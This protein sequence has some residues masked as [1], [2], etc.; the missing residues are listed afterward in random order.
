MTLEELREYEE[1]V[2]TSFIQKVLAESIA[3]NESLEDILK[4]M[5]K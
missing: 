1:A 5:I 2:I 4:S 3:T